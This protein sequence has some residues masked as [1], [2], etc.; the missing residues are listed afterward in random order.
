MRK[1]SLYCDGAATLR[2][3][4]CRTVLDILFNCLTAW[5]A[6]IICFTAEEAWLARGCEAE[7]SVHLRAFPDIPLGWRD[8]ILAAK[9]ETVRRVRRVVT[10]AIEIERSEKN[11]RSS[12]QASPVVYA[13]SD[14]V[15]AFDGLDLAEIGITSGAE[16]KSGAIPAEAFTLDDEPSIGVVTQLAR[17]EKC[18]RCWRILED[19]GAHGR[20]DLCGRCT[21]VITGRA[22]G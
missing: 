6:P 17:G 9:W 8:D 19:V 4:A 21:D 14:S 22:V 10:G 13:D 12:L 15:L 3:R 5:L 1:D 18:G 2:R 7:E 20:P 11:I 16:L